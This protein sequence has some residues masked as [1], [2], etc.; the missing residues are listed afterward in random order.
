MDFSCIMGDYQQIQPIVKISVEEVHPAFG[1]PT[2]E[3]TIIA[4]QGPG[5]VDQTQERRLFYD[6]ALGRFL[7]REDTHSPIAGYHGHDVSTRDSKILLAFSAFPVFKGD[8]EKD[9]D[10]SPEE[11]ERLREH[12]RTNF[13]DEAAY[14]T[15]GMGA[16]AVIITTDGQII[17]GVRNTPDYA[18]E[19][20]GAATWM[21]LPRE[22]PKGDTVPFN[23]LKTV[24]GRLESEYGVTRDRLKGDPEF[25]SFVQYGRQQTFEGDLNFLAYFDGTAEH[26]VGLWKRAQEQDDHSGLV[27]F[28][29]WRLTHKS[30]RDGT[31]Y[32]VGTQGRLVGHPKKAP[33]LIV[34]STGYVLETL[35]QDEGIWNKVVR[36]HCL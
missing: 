29:T 18:G 7:E 32:E 11:F 25:H 3:L 28:P 9:R 30:L 33:H 6:E 22:V 16:N 24:L 23:P 31:M 14:F 13:G 10:R 34:D 36:K 1:G 19:V 12:G 26:L 8:W 27:T 4:Q 21:R 5:Q 15:N 17:A 2:S 35:I 20:H